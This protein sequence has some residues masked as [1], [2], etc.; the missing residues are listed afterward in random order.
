MAGGCVEISR[1]DRATSA[2]LNVKSL[3]VPAMAKHVGIGREGAINRF[4]SGKN[5][6]DG[7]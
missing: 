2:E 6:I 3:T 7:R 1:L 4:D 5:F